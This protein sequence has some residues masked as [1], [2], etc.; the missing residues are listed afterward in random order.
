VSRNTEHV[1]GFPHEHTYV[2]PQK[3]DKRVFLFRIQV[4]PDRGRL[5]RIVVDQLN[6]IVLVGL[7]VLPQCL[8]LWDLQLAGGNLGGV[9][10]GLLHAN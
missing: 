5:A 1:S 7:D 4:G 2:V 10:H 3:P 9:D 8:A 6:L